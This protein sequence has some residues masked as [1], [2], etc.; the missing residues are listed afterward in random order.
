VHPWTQQRIDKIVG[1]HR[2]SRGH[3]PLHRRRPPAR[4]PPDPASACAP[5]VAAVALGS[6]ALPPGATTPLEVE[7]LWPP[8]LCGD[9]QPE[10]TATGCGAELAA[11]RVAAPPTDTLGGLVSQLVVASPLMPGTQA[12][13]VAL[14]WC[15]PSRGEAQLEGITTGCEPESAAN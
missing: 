15:A 3:I 7:L 10:G 9:E 2:V 14:S 6:H 13:V 1:S 8:P 12:S 4:L 11:D 5:S